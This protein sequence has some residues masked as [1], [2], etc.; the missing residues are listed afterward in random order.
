MTQNL[1]GSWVFP[2]KIEINDI[3]LYA[4]QLSR[5]DFGN[6]LNFD[7]SNTMEVHSSF[8]G[9]LILAKKEAERKGSSLKIDLSADMSKLFSLLRIKDYFSD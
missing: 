8:V 7:L 2:E 9:F 6:N 1:N 4:E 5:V 3:H